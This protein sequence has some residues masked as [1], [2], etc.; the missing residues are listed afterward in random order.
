MIKKDFVERVLGGYRGT[1]LHMG[2]SIVT[3]HDTVQ[4]VSY[5]QSH[6]TSVVAVRLEILLESDVFIFQVL[7]C[8]RG[9]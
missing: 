7:G 1:T 2:Q 9:S 8:L 4:P 3:V 5:F 6:L